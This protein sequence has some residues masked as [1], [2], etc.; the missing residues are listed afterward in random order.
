M[1][2]A[3]LP[4]FGGSLYFLLLLFQTCLS[5]LLPESTLHS[6]AIR[7][8]P[9]SKIPTLLCRIVWIDRLMRP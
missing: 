6:L 9:T 5:S 8:Q 4:H 1:D 3:L 7:F 2:Y